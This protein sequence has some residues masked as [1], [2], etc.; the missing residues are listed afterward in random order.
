M[1]S[2]GG[3]DEFLNIPAA[4][5]QLREKIA[6]TKTSESLMSLER[7]FLASREEHS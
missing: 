2:L 7:A 5:M 3:G 1:L 4:K 6:R